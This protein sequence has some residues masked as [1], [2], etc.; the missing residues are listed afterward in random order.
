MCFLFDNNTT[1]NTIDNQRFVIE[2]TTL[3]IKTRNIS[4]CKYANDSTTTY[5][6]KC[7]RSI[8]TGAYVNAVNYFATVIDFTTKIN[9]TIQLNISATGEGLTLLLVVNRHFIF[10]KIS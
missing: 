2:H 3:L 4:A 8:N 6:S 1:M 7:Y 5:Q 9:A 10:S